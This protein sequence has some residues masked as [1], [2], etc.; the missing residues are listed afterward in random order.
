MQTR[1]HLHDFISHPHRSHIVHI[2]GI[3]GIG[4][5]GL[6]EILHR[7][8]VH[9]QGSDLSE[10]ANIQRLRDRGVNIFIGH[11]AQNIDGVGLVCMS[12]AV[13]ADNAEVKQA[14][15]RNI[16]II[17]RADLLAEMMRP[18]K[19]VAI[20]GTH[21][22]TTTTGLAAA[23]CAAG[24]IDPTIIAGGMMTAYKSNVYLGK[25]RWAIV[26]A[27]ESDGTFLHLPAMVKI[28]TN[29]DPE[30]LSHYGDFAHL[31]SAFVTFLQDLPFYGLAII[32]SDHQG[33]RELARHV[34]DR[35]IV[36]YGLQAGAQ[37]RA[38]N[39]RVEDSLQKFDIA[40]D[41]TLIKDFASPLLGDH[42]VQNAL[43]AI[44]LGLAL[45]IAPADIKTG[46]IGF[47][48]MDRRFTLIGEFQG[49]QVIDDYAHHPVEIAAALASARALQKRVIAVVQP[50]RYSRVRDLFDDFVE[51]LKQADEIIMLPVYAAGEI[52]I[53]GFTAA[54]L[55]AALGVEVTKED[56]LGDR[57]SEITQD[58]DIIL[59]MGAGSVSQM[60][61]GLI[62]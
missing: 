20:S 28:V 51:S 53:A 47:A 5:S 19:S 33:L 38:L 41:D 13:T 46:L 14:R 11:A 9:V 61:R 55:A 8:G 15:L 3:G 25:G 49:A 26:E 44:T 2:I 42:N 50:H 21:G 6:A 1:L 57:L 32:C 31:K 34:S 39:L 58:D 37:I 24:N 10:N 56:E 60:I 35:E 30:H 29:I 7:Q 48:G 40:V 12:S 22:K 23:I 36:T 4:M 62:E 43:A 59:S 45:D 18:F 52:E 54:E 16:P 17:R 27:D